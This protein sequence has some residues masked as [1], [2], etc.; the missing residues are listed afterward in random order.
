M[1]I[2]EILDVVVLTEAVSSHKLRKG[3]LGTI[4]EML[5]NDAF[6]VEFADTKGIT[7]AMIPLKSSSLMKVYYEPVL[8]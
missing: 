1:D 2:F 7:Y 3:E 6:L 5:D 8:S 4:V